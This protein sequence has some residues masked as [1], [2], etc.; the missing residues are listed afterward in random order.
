[1]TAEARPGLIETM[2]LR[3]DG[4]IDR[5][6]LHLS[7]LENSAQTMGIPCS[8]EDVNNILRSLTPT[9]QDLRLR[10]ELAAD[11]QIKVTTSPLVETDPEKPWR[12][13]LAA[14]RLDAADPLLRHKTTRRDC[15]AQARREFPADQADEVLL[16][17][18]QRQVC[19]GTITNVFV[20]NDRDPVLRTPHLECGL[21]RGVLRQQLLDE[22]RAVEA[23][24]TVADLRAA[25]SLHVGNSLRGLLPAV[26]LE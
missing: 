7:R 8:T 26:L 16:L 10:L 5:I 9:G 17:N 25:S 14:T 22:K 19:E 4:S 24:L 11:G 13:A 15:Y 3:R 12:L 6:A 20:R 21:L 2:R 1:M 18:G 23:V